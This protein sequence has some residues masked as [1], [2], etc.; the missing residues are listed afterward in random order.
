MTISDRVRQLAT[1]LA[2]GEE[3]GSVERR[4]PDTTWKHLMDTGVLRALQPARWGG[5][6]AA[7]VDFLDGVFEVARVAPSAGWIAGVVGSHPWQLSLF[8]EQTQQ[9][10]WGDDSARMLSSSY[11][12]TG[13]IEPVKC[14]YRV[15]GRWSFSSGCDHC[16]GVIV[17][18]FA[19][20]TEAGDA[21]VSDFGSLVLLREEYRI[22]DTWFTSGLRGTG[23]N[24]IVVDGVVVPAHRFLSHVRYEYQPGVLSPGQHTNTSSRYKLP[25]AVLFNLVLVAPTLG[26]AQ[27]FVDAWAEATV[28][29]RSS[30]GDSAGE[31]SL[32]QRHLA[33]AYWTLDA[34]IMKMRRAAIELTDAAQAGRH[35]ERESRARYRWDINRGCELVG[36]AISDLY[37]VSSGRVVYVDHP[38]HVR[39]Q[40]IVS[41]LGHMF[42]SADTTALAYGARQLDATPPEVFL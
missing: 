3:P 25:W 12:P 36:D 8:P 19:G 41:A 14:G 35:V 11:A 4:L 9:E 29:R 6:E 40:N 31:D 1:E 10:L 32:M 5:Q 38:L 30:W 37:R 27:G 39:Y 17:G 13:T 42:L 18:G 34:A 7:L 16:D 2:A 22:E 28:K 24:D 33:Q 26:M 20:K 15:S 23:S 21:Q